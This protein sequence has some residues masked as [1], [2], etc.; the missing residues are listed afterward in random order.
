VTGTP[1]APEQVS[2]LHETVVQRLVFPVHDDGST[3]PLYVECTEGAARLAELVRDRRSILVPPGERLSFASYFNAFPA[4]YW[5]RWTIVRSVELR[6]QVNGNATVT[7]YRSN[8]RGNQQRVASEPAGKRFGYLSFELPLAPFGDGGWYWFE[9]SGS[10]EEST[11]DWA[12]WLVASERAAQGR[13]TLAITTFNRP[14]D[15]VGLLRSL[16]AEPATMDRVDRVVVVDQGTK[17]V[18]DHPEYTRVAD[19]ASG[20]VEIIRQPNLGGSGGFARG[21]YEASYN[22]DSGYV[23]LLDDDVRVEPEG[24]LRGLAFQD[25]VR[26]DMIVGG[27]MLNM[28]LPSMLHSFGEK[29]NRYKFMWGPAPHVEEAHDFAED[30]LRE[31]EWMHRRIDVDY[32]GWWMCLVPTKVVR[33]LGLAMPVFIKWDDAEFGLRAQDAGIPTVSLPGMSVWHVPWTDKDDTTDWQAYYHARNRILMALVHSPY[34]RGG[35]LLR[36]SLM[37]QVKHVL[38]MEYSAAELRLW[39]LEDIL[40]G[41]S[42][43]HRDIG[44]KLDEVRAYRSEQDDAKVVADPMGFPRVKRLKP[45]KKGKEPTAP[46]GAVGRVVTAAAGAVRQ[47]L[48]ERDTSRVYPEAAVQAQDARWW[49]LSQFD[50]AVVSTADGTGAA[51]YKRDRQRAADVMR[52]SIVLHEQLLTRWN[53]MS[54]EYRASVKDFTSPQAWFPTWGIDGGD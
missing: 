13:V 19:R 44:T 33:E 17:N 35:E 53:T 51:W 6:V 10:H 46:R 27:H 52:R 32:N 39:A 40:S 21:M 49:M 12:E 50:S 3:M 5:R 9:V 43:L 11:V 14:D 15:C 29:V 37:V 4:S 42:H 38:A 18:A 7:V 26:Q 36:H 16:V 20:K 30:T 34:A 54:D 8:S 2:A 24:I 48:P 1:L 47:A 41:P 23:L 28:F 22:S 31:T 45:P 25:L